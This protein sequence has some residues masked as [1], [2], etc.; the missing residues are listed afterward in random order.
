MKNKAKENKTK[1]NSIVTP[2]FWKWQEGQISENF[3]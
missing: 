2:E 3:T 1:A